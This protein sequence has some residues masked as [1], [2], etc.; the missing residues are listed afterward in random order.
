LAR[1]V[2]AITPAQ[3]RKYEDRATLMLF[4][5]RSVD[6]ILS[7]Q[8]PVGSELLVRCR[9][10]ARES[11]AGAIYKSQYQDTIRVLKEMVRVVRTRQGAARKEARKLRARGREGVGGGI[12]SSAA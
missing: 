2:W 5:V 9:L 12:C 4:E 1:E 11:F 7:G 8:K 6:Q 3:K 10:E